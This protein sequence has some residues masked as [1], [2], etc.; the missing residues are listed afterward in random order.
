MQKY[1]VEN[2]RV[3]LFLCLFESAC[4]AALVICGQYSQLAG[5]VGAVDFFGLYVFIYIY[6]RM[7]LYIYIYVYIYMECTFIY[8]YI[9]THMYICVHMYV[10]IRV[11]ISIY[12]HF[13][14][15]PATRY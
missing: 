8:I 14:I 7:S 10:Y 12:I 4:A 1:I 6:I 15:W 5:C 3:C 13:N 9:R 2:S 11:Y